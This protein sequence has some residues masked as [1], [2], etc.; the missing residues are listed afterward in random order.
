[1]TLDPALT[2]AAGALRDE[3][4]DRLRV[5]YRAVGADLPEADLI[6][7][8]IAGPWGIR[9]GHA[10]VDGTTHAALLIPGVPALPLT[11]AEAR[12]LADRLSALAE[13]IS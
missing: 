9:A 13:S 12:H 4:R 1:M 3:T 10:A 8:E 6:C 11:P 5:A 7:D 2:A